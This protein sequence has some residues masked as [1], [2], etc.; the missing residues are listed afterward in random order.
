M[1]NIKVIK[2]GVPVSF[3]GFYYPIYSLVIIHEDGKNTL[4]RIIGYDGL[5][6]VQIK[7]KSGKLYN[8][9]YSEI[10]F[11]EDP[12]EP[13]MTLPE[14]QRSANKIIDQYRD[15]PISINGEEYIIDFGVDFQYDTELVAGNRHS[16][17][18]AI[19]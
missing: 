10:I 5:D 19:D 3:G 12:H 2:Y 7:S 6:R 4:G 9:K 13:L 1:R 17:A 18:A 16:L 14:F 11:Y 8:L 15:E